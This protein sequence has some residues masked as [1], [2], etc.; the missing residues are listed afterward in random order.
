MICITTIAKKDRNAVH[1]QVII[2]LMTASFS[3]GS[4]VPIVVMLSNKINIDLRMK[5]EILLTEYFKI[6][7]SL[8][9]G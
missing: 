4:P 7:S 8:S 1:G 6:T 9:D 5:Y 2:H 3:D